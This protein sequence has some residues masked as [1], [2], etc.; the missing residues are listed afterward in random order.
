VTFKPW[1]KLR[2][3]RELNFAGFIFHDPDTNHVL[4]TQEW[5][6]TFRIEFNNG[7]YSDDDIVDV[8]TQRLTT[9]VQ[10]LQKRLHPGG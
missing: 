9:P 10:H 4:E 5:Q 8:F 3:V 6:N 1:P 7:A 2:G